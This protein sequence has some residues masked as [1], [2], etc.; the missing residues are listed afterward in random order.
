[1]KN[2]P[3]LDTI[4][5]Y[6]MGCNTGNVELMISTFMPNVTHYFPSHKSVSG[7]DT[8]ANYWAAFNNKTRK[9]EWTVDRFMALDDE[10]VIEWTMISTFLE[11]GQKDILRGTEWYVFRD[12]KIAEIRAYFMPTPNLTDSELVGFPYKERGYPVREE[13]NNT[14]R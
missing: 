14:G 3:Y 11:D 2:H 4:Q 12:G 8:L 1:M 10:A 13:E 5:T 9:T 6:F 7:A